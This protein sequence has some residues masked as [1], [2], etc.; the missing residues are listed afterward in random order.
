MGVVNGPILVVD[1][2][3]MRSLVQGQSSSATVHRKLR[4]KNNNTRSK[5]KFVVQQVKVKVQVGSCWGGAC[6]GTYPDGVGFSR[7][8]ACGD[9]GG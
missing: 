9:G 5:Y 3:R 1:G 4:Q 8:P 2:A 7:V 6:L